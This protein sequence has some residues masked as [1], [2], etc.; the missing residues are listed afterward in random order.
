M[1]SV[2][3]V[4]QWS[5]HMAMNH[6]QT[7]RAFCTHYALFQDGVGASVPVLKNRSQSSYPFFEHV[8]FFIIL[9]Y[10]CNWNMFSLIHVN[11]TRAPP[12]HVCSSTWRP[13]LTEELNINQIRFW[14]SGHGE[15]PWVNTREGESWVTE[16][17]AANS[18]Y[19]GFV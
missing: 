16:I 8:F 6:D 3:Y 11:G 19:G 4:A 1:F 14:R 5:R 15:K 17:F 12:Y 10:C 2:Y 18:C 13:D 9:L 7:Q